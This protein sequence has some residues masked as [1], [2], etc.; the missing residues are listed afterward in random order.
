M[1]HQNDYNLLE[2]RFKRLYP[3]NT[4]E[5]FPRLLQGDIY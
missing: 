5:I 2:R 3:F 1:T 4:Y